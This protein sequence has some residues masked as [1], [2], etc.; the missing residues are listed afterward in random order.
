LQT[1]YTKDDIDAATGY[2]GQ[3]WGFD[4]TADRKSLLLGGGGGMVFELLARLD[5]PVAPFSI[6]IARSGAD[7][8][9]SW[10]SSV[11]GAVIQSSVT[12]APASFTD[13][14]PQPPVTVVQD[15][16][17]ATLRPEAGAVFYRLRK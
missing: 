9:L 14:S 7:I 8:V 5:E 6:S 10:P 3:Y 13:L 4:I 11:T 2:S 17:Q 1:T 16:N 15:Q 12:I